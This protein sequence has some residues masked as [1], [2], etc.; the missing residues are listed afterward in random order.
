M[1]LLQFMDK[2]IYYSGATTVMLCMV[3]LALVITLH[4]LWLAW[5]QRKQRKPSRCGLGG[6]D[7]KRTPAHPVTNEEKIAR[8]VAQSEKRVWTSGEDDIGTLAADVIGNRGGR[9]K[10]GHV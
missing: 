9:R 1:N 4:D 7:R 3:M 6:G 5:C 10:A 2:H 8:F